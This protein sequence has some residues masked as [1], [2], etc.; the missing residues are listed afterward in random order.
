[1]HAFIYFYCL[2]YN[3]RRRIYAR[4]GRRQHARMILLVQLCAHTS[5]TTVVDALTTPYYSVAMYDIPALTLTL[6][7]LI[8]A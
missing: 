2:E 6:T 4:H 3:A 8:V 5:G 7:L 1:M